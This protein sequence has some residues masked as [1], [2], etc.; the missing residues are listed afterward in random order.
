MTSV[1]CRF[2]NNYHAVTCQTSHN[3]LPL[4]LAM[5][6]LSDNCGM[7]LCDG[8]SRRDWLKIGS[9][10]LGSLSLPSLLAQK[11]AAA[12]GNASQGSSFGKAK[13]VIIFGLV[14]GPP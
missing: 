13:S 6:N 11:A 7:R 4:Y 1:V 12:S 10:A 8:V 9:V 2:A 3:T 5:L 14:G